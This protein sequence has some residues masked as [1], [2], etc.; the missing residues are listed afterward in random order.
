MKKRLQAAPRRH[1]CLKKS[2]P[3]NKYNKFQTKIIGG[4]RLKEWRGGS[5]G[6]IT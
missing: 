3:H 1:E 2:Y 6:K 4:G 5:T